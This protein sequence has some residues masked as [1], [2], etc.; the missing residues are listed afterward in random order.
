MIERPQPYVGVSGVVS[1]EQQ[2]EIIDTFHESELPNYGRRLL[3]GVKAVHKTQYLDIENKYGPEWYPVGEEAFANAVAPSPDTTKSANIAQVYLDT[4]HVGDPAY[5]DA[6]SRR[7]M[8][9][10]ASW[11][12]GVQFDMLPWHDDAAMLPFLEQLKS[13]YDTQLL[14]QCHSEAMETLGPREVVRRL[15]RYAHILDYILFDASHGKGVRLN[16]EA[17]R[18]FVDEAYSSGKLESVGIAAAGGL[19]A[20]VVRDD[21][22][23]LVNKY[24]DLSWDAEGQLHPVNTQGRRPLDRQAVREYFDASATVLKE[25]Y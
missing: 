21:L 9:R 2:T 13:E 17:L 10:G 5:R 7:I 24:P 15:G 4:D 20:M 11:L 1:L 12:N 22:P 14:L 18:P 8:E 25:V 6:F 16:T 3:L 19:N 23:E